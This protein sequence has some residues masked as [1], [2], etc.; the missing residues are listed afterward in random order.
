MIHLPRPVLLAEDDELDA[1]LTLDALQAAGIRNPVVHVADG[2][3]AL[4]YLHRRGAHAGRTGPDPVVVILDIKMPRLDGLQVLEQMRADPVL[5]RLPVVLLTSSRHE[6]DL[7]RGW[8]AG[9]NAYVVKPLSPS[10]YSEAVR[11]LG[12][13][14]LRLNEPPVT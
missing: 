9:V 11:T 8:G 6:S 1:E 2:S 14:W 3:L 7:A 4:D 10:Q 13:F 5:R 12:E